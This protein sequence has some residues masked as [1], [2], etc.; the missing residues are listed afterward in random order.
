MARYDILPS[1][2]MQKVKKDLKDIKK[3]L[4]K[5]KTKVKRKQSYKVLPHK[6]VVEVKKN[7]KDIKKTL[8]KKAVSE[9]APKPVVKV[10][11]FDNYYDM[12]PHK[13]VKELELQLTTL[14]GKLKQTKGKQE[15]KERKNLLPKTTKQL[16][17]SM[18]KL[19]K[20]ISALLELFEK[21]DETLKS[22]G[23]EQVT[24]STASGTIDMTPLTNELSAV[25]SRLEDLSA[26]NEEMAKGILVIAEMLKENPPT[27][28]Q[29]SSDKSK[30]TGFL[31]SLRRTETSQD[32]ESMPTPTPGDA[33]DSFYNQPGQSVQPGQP[34]PV[35]KE[36]QAS[37]RRKPNP[38]KPY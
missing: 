20:S 34:S 37:G 12:L 36:G 27:K 16:L 30:D 26:E 7:L 10:T 19:N 35:P 18:S 9:K 5:K 29:D 33:F 6:D 23:A 14:K 31:P 17:N 32:E 21:A 2:D 28:K 11:R 22:P 8:D 4:S 13:K 38:P 25:K 15:T 1:K 3:K 24:I